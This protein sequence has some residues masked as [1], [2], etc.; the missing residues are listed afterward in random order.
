M[1]WWNFF[2]SAQN[3]DDWV[4]QKLDGKKDMIFIFRLQ[5]KKVSVLGEK[6]SYHCHILPFKLGEWK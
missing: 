4:R 3:I 5:T 1:E 2:H 6:F